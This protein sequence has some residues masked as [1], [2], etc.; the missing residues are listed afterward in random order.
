[1]TTNN[2]IISVPNTVEDSTIYN[3]SNDSNDNNNNKDANSPKVSEDSEK[4]E[5][6]DSIFTVEQHLPIVINTNAP[7]LHSQDGR[8]IKIFKENDEEFIKRRFRRQ[9]IFNIKKMCYKLGSF[10]S[11]KV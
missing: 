6:V 9:K 1:M 11:S 2:I 7:T 10:A 8:E 5:D 4:K 3:F